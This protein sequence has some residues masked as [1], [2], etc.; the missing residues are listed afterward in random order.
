MKIL[1]ILISASLRVIVLCLYPLLKLVAVT[2]DS[3]ICEFGILYYILLEALNIVMQVLWI[4]YLLF[5]YFISDNK[6]EVVN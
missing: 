2:Q 1:E 6:A 5:S 4:F 3:Y